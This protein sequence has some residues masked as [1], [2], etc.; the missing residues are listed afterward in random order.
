MSV[1]VDS[2]VIL[3]IFTEDETWFAWFAWFAD[4][5]ERAALTSPFV[6][7]PIINAEISARF[8]RLEEFDEVLPP[9]RFVRLS[10]PYASAFLAGKVFASYRR[11]GG[12]GK[13]PTVDTRSTSLSDLFPEACSHCAVTRSRAH[14]RHAAGSRRPAPTQQTDA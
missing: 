3:D 1:L 14:A 8:S 13:L 12:G 7:N 11:R 4:A 10:L 9:N 5:L 2:N 6:I